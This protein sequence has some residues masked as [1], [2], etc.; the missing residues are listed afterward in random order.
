MKNILNH[1]EEFFG[2]FLLAIYVGL[3]V[4]NVI[5]RYCFNFIL[6]WAEEGILIVFLWSVFLGTITAFRLDRHVA[7]DVIVTRLPKKIQRVLYIAVD[8]LILALNLYLTYLSAV[9]CMKVGLKTTYIL[10]ISYVYIDAA[11]V[12]S[13]GLMAFFG[14]V[15]LVLRARGRYETINSITRALN[16]ADAIAV[17]NPLE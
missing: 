6:S 2:C 14:I 7:I 8:V 16:E 10:K 13:F 4:L 9:L 17:E 15:R 5:L 1:F 3:T 12:V 11:L